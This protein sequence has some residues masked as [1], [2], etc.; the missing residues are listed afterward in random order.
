MF[1]HI[2]VQSVYYCMPEEGPPGLKRWN[3]LMMFCALK[4]CSDYSL[5]NTLL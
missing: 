5:A 1:T 4:D 3:S 2:F